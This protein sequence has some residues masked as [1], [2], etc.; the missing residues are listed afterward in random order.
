MKQLPKRYLMFRPSHSQR[1]KDTTEG[2][3][4]PPSPPPSQQPPIAEQQ[5]KALDLLTQAQKR[6]EV[7]K[8][9]SSGKG[10]NIN[11]TGGKI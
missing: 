4:L 11:I 6:T 1:M 2:K 9:S 10:I 7:S 8:M 3:H 5:V